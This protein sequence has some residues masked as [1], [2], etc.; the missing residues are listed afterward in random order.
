MRK[1]KCPMCSKQ[2]DSRA[3]MCRR[4]KNTYDPPRKGTGAPYRISYGGYVVIMVG[5]KECYQHRVVMEAALKRKL[6]PDEHVHHKDGDKQNN[7]LDNLEVLLAADHHR[8]H[9]TSERAKQMSIKAHAV[10]WSKHAS[11]L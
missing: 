2:K 3:K 10:R 11:A 1:D 9:L 4:C 5:G 8:E 6:R 7:S